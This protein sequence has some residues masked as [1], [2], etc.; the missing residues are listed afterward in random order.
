M[1]RKM[2]RRVAARGFFPD[3]RMAADGAGR[4]RSRAVGA[5]LLASAL[6]VLLAGGCGGGNLIHVKDEAD[7]QQQVIQAKK[8]VV[9]DFYKGGCPTCWLLDPTLDQLADEYRGLVTFARFEL[10]MPYFLITSDALQKKYHIGLFPTVVLIV[11]GEEKKRWPMNY[12]IDDYRKV[13]NELVGAPAPK[14]SKAENP[15]DM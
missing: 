11:G 2:D 9:V 7:F 3:S 12:V 13:L 6:P 10:M 5:C 14:E 8:P 4:R 15:P 1:L